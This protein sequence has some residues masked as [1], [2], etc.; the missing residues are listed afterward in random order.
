[1]TRNNPQTLHAMIVADVMK[2]WPETVSVFNRRR[3]ACPG[4]TMAPFMTVAESAR[5]YK[6]SAEEL[7]EDLMAA[8]RAVDPC[9]AS[10]AGAASR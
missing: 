10:T 5:A 9:G 3:M 7:A 2:L 8:I 1:M 4:C 6:L